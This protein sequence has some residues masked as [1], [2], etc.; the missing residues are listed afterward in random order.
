MWKEIIWMS[1]EEKEIAEFEKNI[2]L[3]NEN[4]LKTFR[5]ISEY[6]NTYEKNALPFL[7]HYTKDDNNVFWNDLKTSVKSLLAPYEKMAIIWKEV[8]IIVNDITEKVLWTKNMIQSH[9]KELWKA[10]DGLSL[11]IKNLIKQ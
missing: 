6:I 8:D 10:L 4:E 1:K 5:I 11:T 7:I 9:W 2:L 3:W